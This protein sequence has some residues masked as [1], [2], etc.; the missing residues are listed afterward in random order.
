MYLLLY[1]NLI[2]LAAFQN[3]SNLK[4]FLWYLSKIPQIITVTRKTVLRI[5]NFY[6]L[7]DVLFLSII[8]WSQPFTK[9]NNYGRAS[10]W[11]GTKLR[12]L[13][14]HPWAKVSETVFVLIV[15]LQS[16]L[17]IPLWLKSFFNV[18]HRKK[19]SCFWDC[20]DRN[21]E[22]CMDRVCHNNSGSTNVNPNKFF[23]FVFPL[24]N[25]YYLKSFRYWCLTQKK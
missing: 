1:I 3:V 21:F 24:S 18:Q 8:I 22:W 4:F 12:S 16:E 25:N 10:C 5:N 2:P 23:K 19:S 15:Q 7:D 9:P 13:E 14:S 17:V 6:I 20:I 11:Q